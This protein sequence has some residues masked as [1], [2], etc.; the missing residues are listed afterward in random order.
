MFAQKKYLLFLTHGQNAADRT[1]ALL[2]L[3]VVSLSTSSSNHEIEVRLVDDLPWQDLLSEAGVKPISHSQRYPPGI[4]RHC[5][6]S[7]RLIF[8]A[9]SSM[10]VEYNESCH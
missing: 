3:L 7:H 5:P 4:F 2:V 8:S 10:S 1:D 9:H 6:F